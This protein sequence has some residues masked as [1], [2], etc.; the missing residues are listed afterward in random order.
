MGFYKNT[1][2]FIKITMMQH[3]TH[4][5]QQHQPSLWI[6][7]SGLSLVSRDGSERVRIVYALA[8]SPILQEVVKQL[9]SATVKC[10]RLCDKLEHHLANMAQFS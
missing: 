6:C 7:S 1:M 10:Q 9:R 8:R 4:S 5:A 2:G 3:C